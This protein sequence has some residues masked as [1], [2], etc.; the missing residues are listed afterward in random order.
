MKNY[1]YFLTAVLL[2]H[3]CSSSEELIVDQS[4]EQR[5]EATNQEHNCTSEEFV[6]ILS[7]MDLSG[8]MVIFQDDQAMLD[9]INAYYS[10]GEY[11]KEFLPQALQLNANFPLSLRSYEVML[12]SLQALHDNN[13][14]EITPTDSLRIIERTSEIL[15]EN[16]KIASIQNQA[17]GED[18]L[19]HHHETSTPLRFVMNEDGVFKSGDKYHK[20]IG[21]I[22]YISTD[23]GKIIQPGRPDTGPGVTVDTI[24]GSG[25]GNTTTNTRGTCTNIIDITFDEEVEKDRRW[26]GSDRR[27]RFEYGVYNNS[28]E[29]EIP[30]PTGGYDKLKFKVANFKSEGKGFRRAGS[31]LCFWYQYTTNHTWNNY[32]FAGKVIVVETGQP[33]VEIPFNTSRTNGFRSARTWTTEALVYNNVDDND[34]KLEACFDRERVDYKTRGVDDWIVINK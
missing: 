24:Y 32:N 19:M 17:N 14:R 28:Y 10:L 8:D 11:Q 15:Q 5:T 34:V 21:G 29:I 20:V 23:L 16:N 18:Y 26:C 4:T 22:R 3:A 12:D 31:P 9:F 6:H 13:G 30:D 7:L 2:L 27:A 1:F 33:D 25:D